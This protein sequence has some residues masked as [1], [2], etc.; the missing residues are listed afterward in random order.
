MKLNNQIIRLQ[1]IKGLIQV[2]IGLNRGKWINTKGILDF[3]KPWNLLT[4]IQ[5]S[6]LIMKLG[7]D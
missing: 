5:V 3:I 4:Q 2:Y 7:S 1:N 6:S